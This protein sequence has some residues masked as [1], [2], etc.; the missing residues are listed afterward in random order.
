MEAGKRLSDDL[1]VE[2]N[3]HYHY[4]LH[5]PNGFFRRFKGSAKA[6]RGW[7]AGVA[8]PEVTEA[9]DFANGSIGLRLRNIGSAACEFMVR[10]AYGSPFVK[11]R[12]VG[13]EIADVYFDSR[14]S[15]GWYDLAV[16]VDTDP[17]FERAFAG[18]VETGRSSMSDPAFGIA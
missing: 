10:D 7:G 13:G 18:H 5:G 17:S 15:H 4:S 9:Y 8:L 16:H 12:V 6:T 11:R 1:P 2:P 3:G 14:S